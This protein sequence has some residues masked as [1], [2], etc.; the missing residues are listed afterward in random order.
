MFSLLPKM[1]IMVKF[2]TGWKTLDWK[3]VN[4]L[5]SNIMLEYFPERI[6]KMF[7]C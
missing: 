4:L 1:D 5:L 3:F 7:N 6:A 2:I